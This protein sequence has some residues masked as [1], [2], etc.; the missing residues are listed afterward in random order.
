MSAQVCI[1]IKRLQSPASNHNAYSDIERDSGITK[2]V[3]LRTNRDAGKRASPMRRWAAN[4]GTRCSAGVQQG[5]ASRKPQWA[6]SWS[7]LLRASFERRA[8]ASGNVDLLSRPFAPTP[9]CRLLQRFAVFVIPLWAY[10]AGA[11]PRSPSAAPFSAAAAVLRLAP[12]SGSEQRL[13]DSP[14]DAMQLTL[15]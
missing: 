14:P 2:H 7:V 5:W 15:I 10:P 3:N 1:R 12:A 8:P 6:A 13:T 4:G 11:R 9:S